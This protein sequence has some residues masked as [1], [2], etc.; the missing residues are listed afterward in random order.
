MYHGPNGLKRIAERVHGL[1]QI[2]AEGLTRLGCQVANEMF[3][4]TIRVT[5]G[6]IK[7]EQV[8][9]QA[10][11]HQVNLRHYDDSSFGISLDETTTLDDVETLFKTFSKDGRLW[12]TAREL[13]EVHTVSIPAPFARTTPFLTHEAVS[14]THLTLPT[15]A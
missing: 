4:D 11:Q 8:L 15:K 1:T 5:P 10:K 12:F 2:L 6:L 13:A 7:V 14:Y 3:F 9:K